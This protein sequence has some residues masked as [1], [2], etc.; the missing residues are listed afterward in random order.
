MKLYQ[1][2]TSFRTESKL[3]VRS[4]YFY[5]ARRTA[6]N[7]TQ[8]WFDKARILVVQNVRMKGIQNKIIVSQNAFIIHIYGLHH[9]KGK[10]ANAF[11]N[12]QL[13]Q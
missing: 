4:H 5:G 3:I 12:I 2:Q 13:S 9:Q 6:G 8:S 11:L 10:L 7:I 1:L